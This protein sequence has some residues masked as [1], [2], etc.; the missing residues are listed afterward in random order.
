[1][2]SYR[3]LR[4]SSSKDKVICIINRARHNDALL[5]IPVRR[6]PRLQRRAET[7]GHAGPRALLVGLAIAG[8]PRGHRRQRRLD[9]WHGR[10]GGKPRERTPCLRLLNNPGNRGK[11]YSVRHGMLEAH[12]EWVLFSDADLSTPIEDVKRLFAAA[13][14][15][16]D[17]AIGSRAVDR[18]LVSKSPVRTSGTLRALLQPGHACGHRVA[19]SRHP[20]RV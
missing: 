6:H 2:R 16:A 14:R 1:M 5:T 12:G 20:V 8:V 4:R 13:S 17:I 9:G 10:A 11:G 7:P 15:R 19:L 3:C 18:S